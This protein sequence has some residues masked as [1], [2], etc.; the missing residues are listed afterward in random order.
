LTL[1]HTTILG[2]TILDEA[3]ERVASDVCDHLRDRANRTFV[4]LN[5]HSIVLAEHDPTIKQAIRSASDVLCDGVGLALAGRLLNNAVIH[6]VYGYEFF[7]RLSNRLSTRKGSR[8]FFLG[9]NEAWVDTLIKR[10]S[11][12]FPGITV[13][14]YAPP[15]KPAFPDTDIQYMARRVSSFRPDVVW[16]G[17]G[18][19]KQELLLPQLINY[20]NVPCLAAIGAVFDFYSGHVPHAP[21]WVRHMG[22]QW[23]HRLTLEP[24]RLWRR[25]LISTPL[26]L[27]EVF[28][29]YVRSRRG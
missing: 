15:F 14:S 16:V 18:S 21:A 23:L 29:E 27:S 12:D 11:E 9:G 5:P 10:Y 1:R 2:Y 26:F 25:T 8:A 17:L 28:R 6:R 4:F 20:C 7:L 22:L 19:P 24:G 3:V 13:E